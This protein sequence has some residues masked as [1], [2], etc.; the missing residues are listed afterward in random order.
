M[1]L[2]NQT[3]IILRKKFFL[4]HSAETCSYGAV[5]RELSAKQ[6]QLLTGGVYK[7]SVITIGRILR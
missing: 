7:F 2:K 1:K 6:F 3:F 5:I 4:M